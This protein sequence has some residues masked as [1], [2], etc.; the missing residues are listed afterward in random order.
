MS[1]GAYTAG[2]LDAAK[3]L[4]P[5]TAPGLSHGAMLGSFREAGLRG[6]WSADEEEESL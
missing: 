1:G 5:G 2:D 4:L 6:D 3:A